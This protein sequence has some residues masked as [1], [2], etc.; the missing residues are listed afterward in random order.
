MED[1]VE[2]LI[3]NAGWFSP[4]LLTK[5]SIGFHWLDFSEWAYENK[6]RSEHVLSYNNIFSMYPTT[7]KWK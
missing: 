6:R 1:W 5:V 4:S 7:L 2:S 3:D